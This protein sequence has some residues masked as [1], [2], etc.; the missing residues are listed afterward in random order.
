MKGMLLLISEL[1]VLL[2]LLVEVVDAVDVAVVVAAA[3]VGVEMNSR[4]QRIRQ[5]C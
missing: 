3:V 4:T 2:V 5:S 1:L